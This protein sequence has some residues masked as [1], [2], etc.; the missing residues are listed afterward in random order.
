M[1]DGLT[2]ALTLSL[3]APPTAGA[4]LEAGPT[5]DAAAV[6]TAE[7]T[8]L[9]SAEGADQT[10]ATDA[11]VADATAEATTAEATTAEA[12]A[13][14]SGADASVD[15]AADSAVDSVPAVEPLAV[16]APPVAAYQADS[17][18]IEA[19]PIFS[20]PERASRADE[21]MDASYGRPGLGMMISGISLTAVGAPLLGIGLGI[22]YTGRTQAAILRDAGQFDDPQLEQADQRARNGTITA[23]VGGVVTAVGVPLMVSGIIKYKRGKDRRTALRTVTPDLALGRGGAS[24]GV[25]MRF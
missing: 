11:V 6:P 21:P 23:I 4:A 10:G 17:A 24:V 20:E 12:T 5:A 14:E 13:A 15:S 3:F 19:A 22:G 7:V 9:A 2:I 25:H 18:E 1:T 8:L 16:A